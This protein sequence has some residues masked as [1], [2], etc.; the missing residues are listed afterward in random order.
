MLLNAMPFPVTV[1]LLQLG[2]I[3]LY[4]LVVTYMRD[5]TIKHLTW[6]F[7][8]IVVPL[9]LL[10]LASKVTH[11]LALSYV[12][13]SFVH[14]VKVSTPIFTI[15]VSRYVLGEKPSV[16][17]MCTTIPIMLGIVLCSASEKNY[18]APGMV[19]ALVGTLF[20][21]M[22]N[23]FTKKALTEKVADEFNI[24]IWTDVVAFL[25]MIPLWLLFEGL[26]VLPY[27]T[28]PYIMGLSLVNGLT[29]FLQT[30]FAFFV[31]GQISSLTYAI[32]NVT[33]RV[34]II[35]GS[36]LWF[37]NAV[38]W[39]NYLGMGSAFF[40]VLLYTKFRY[41]SLKGKKEEEDEIATA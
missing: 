22:G 36:I 15:M 9:G 26:P 37:R 7:A 30:L 24:L 12:P 18:N 13:V 2:T 39:S 29:V 1:A 10:Q 4:S 8:K 41:D 23:V 6:D 17:I 31:M 40:G 5:I 27:L 21:V 11:Q 28:K 20:F 14:S 38:D 19:A 32:L 34:V 35:S 3:V 16:R 25:C 33:K